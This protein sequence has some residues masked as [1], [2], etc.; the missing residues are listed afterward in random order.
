MMKYLFVV[1][2]MAGSAIPF[3]GHAAPEAPLAAL[4]AIEPGYWELRSRGDQS[5][6]RSICVSDPAALLN[7]QHEGAP[8]SRFVIYNA[9]RMAT[10]QYSC[11][12]AGNGQTTIRVETPRLVQIESQGVRNRE[13]FSVQLEGRRLGLCG[14][15]KVDA[16][17]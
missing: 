7:L 16:R 6:N 12:S 8:C 1:V 15:A 17:R 5:E 3:I 2:A 10:V 9:Q 4:G 11:A 14:A 13:P